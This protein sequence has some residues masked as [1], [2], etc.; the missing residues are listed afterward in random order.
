M[1]GDLLYR[2]GAYRASV[3][4]SV[5]FFSLADVPS[6]AFFVHAHRAT[7][8]AKDKKAARA[9]RAC[10]REVK[11]ELRCLMSH[12]LSADGQF[13]PLER[14]FGE[15]LGSGSP[16]SLS[17]FRRGS[18][19]ARRNGEPLSFGAVRCVCS[20]STSPSLRFTQH[21]VEEALALVRRVLGTFLPQG[22][23]P[24]WSRCWVS[25]PYFTPPVFFYKKRRVS[26]PASYH[27]R[28]PPQ[29]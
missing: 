26:I 8:E 15:Y 19:S 23:T 24:F 13:Q 21:L 20:H 5:P 1:Q 14:R 3:E 22:V 25:S 28:K 29:L 6:S 11:R 17:R 4:L 9:G 18:R 27:T 7:Q 12:R 16:R 2:D 10:R